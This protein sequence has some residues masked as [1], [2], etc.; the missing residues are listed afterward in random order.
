MAPH[1]GVCG[2]ARERETDAENIQSARET[3]ARRDVEQSAVS[4]RQISPRGTGCRERA[5]ILGVEGDG[6][7]EAPAN[8]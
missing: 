4:P 5:A 7:C 1:R 2:V 6:A 3:G 8:R